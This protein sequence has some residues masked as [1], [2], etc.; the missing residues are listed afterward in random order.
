MNVS[1]FAREDAYFD[2]RG[3]YGRL[4]SCEAG[5]RS[6]LALVGEV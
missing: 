2:A 4:T 6:G 3:I 5:V 1:R